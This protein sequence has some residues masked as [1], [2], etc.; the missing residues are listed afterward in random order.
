MTP[1]KT[2]SVTEVTDAFVQSCGES[3]WNYTV[4]F[5]RVTK[6]K[7]YE[8]ATLLGSGILVKARK[9]YAILTADHV[10][11][12]LPTSG[13]L[14]LI[15]SNKPEKTTIDV[16]GLKYVTIG[17]G[18][19]PEWGPDIGAVLLSPS[20]VS[21]LAARKSYYN[22]GLRREQ[23]LSDPPDNQ[24][25]IWIVQGFIEEMTRLN[26]NPFPHERVMS[27]C[28]YSAGGGIGSYILRD[29]H[30]Y[31]DFPLQKSR[32]N[33]RIEPSSGDIPYNFA[34]CSGGGLWHVLFE[35]TANAELA[36]AQILLQ[37]LTYFQKTSDAKSEALKCHGLKS[38]YD[39]AYSAL[40]QRSF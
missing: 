35:K 21:G 31:Y 3:I 14:G 1:R 26:P 5:L 40:E 34:G 10:L 27:F 30:D 15:L 23:I 20:I 24:K 32:S 7:R 6:S 11:D 33:L 4:G 38:V 36:V 28:Q 17:R 18:N 22:L 25:G 12:V 13:R 39:V 16:T 9:T 29:N 37:G 8:D 2:S 19:N